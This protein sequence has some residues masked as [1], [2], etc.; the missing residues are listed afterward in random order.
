MSSSDEHP[1]LPAGLKNAVLA[2]AYVAIAVVSLVPGQYRPSSGV[3]P[4]PAEHAAAYLVLGALSC[5][6][7]PSRLSIGAVTLANLVFAGV[8]EFLQLFAP[9]R[10]A[11]FGDFAGSATGA[12]AGMLAVFLWLRK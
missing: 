12:I 5:L 3:L 1:S 8:L 10:V 9:G 7:R 6:L 11:A 4:G 2:A